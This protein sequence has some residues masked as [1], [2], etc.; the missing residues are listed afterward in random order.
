MVVLIS[1]Q[2]GA[3]ATFEQVGSRALILSPDDFLIIGV[4]Y[5]Y[6]VGADQYVIVK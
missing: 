1:A 5:K 3:V 6:S 2:R 4:P